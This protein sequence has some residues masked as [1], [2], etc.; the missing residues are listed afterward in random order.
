VP[1]VRAIGGLV[2]TVFDRDN[3]VR[4]YEERNGYVFHQDDQA[5]LESAMVRAI[6]LWYEHPGEFRQLILN[7]MRQDHSWAGAGQ[8]YL[9]IYDHIRY[10]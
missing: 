6:G 1:I 9:N 3:S 8:D 5:A 2:D 7:G 10:K 4:P